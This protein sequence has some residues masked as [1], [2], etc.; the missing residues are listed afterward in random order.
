M[1][2]MGHMGYN[3]HYGKNRGSIDNMEVLYIM[4]K[5]QIL[6]TLLIVLSLATMGIAHHEEAH[7]DEDAGDVPN[8]DEEDTTSYDPFEN[9]YCSCLINTE[10]T[11]IYDPYNGGPYAAGYIFNVWLTPEDEQEEDEIIYDYYK[12]GVYIGAAAGYSYSDNSFYQSDVSIF[13]GES[14]V[15][16]HGYN[17]YCALEGHE[18]EG[19]YAVLNDLEQY[20]CV[21]DEATGQGVLEFE[22][23][24][25]TPSPLSV[26]MHATWGGI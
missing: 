24:L 20:K 1:D 5:I 10:T 2:V 15:A 8:V 3:Y 14:V 18:N 7:W 12:S 9:E 16:E 23:V 13:C 21:E 4:E 6:I 22:E 19:N 25:Y 26:C 17:H 11:G